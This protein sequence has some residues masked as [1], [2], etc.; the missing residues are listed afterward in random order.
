MGG[1][2]LNSSQPEKRSPCPGRVRAQWRQVDTENREAL[3]VRRQ[4]MRMLG[5][6][7]DEI[8][9]HCDITFDLSLES[10]LES[11]AAVV[12]LQ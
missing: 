6:P 11:L 2:S 10:E 12:W 5:M 1:W 3:E 8:S 7:E 9:E 4:W